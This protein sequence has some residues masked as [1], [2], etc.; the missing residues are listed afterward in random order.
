MLKQIS[1]VEYFTALALLVTL[2]YLIIL[3]IFYLDDFRQLLRCKGMLLN[4]RGE[5]V[6][7]CNQ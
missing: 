2:Y 4:K 3:L 6:P 1:W 5:T 7:E